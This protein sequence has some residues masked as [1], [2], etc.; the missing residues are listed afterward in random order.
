MFKKSSR[1]S[2]IMNKIKIAFL[3]LLLTSC[4]IGEHYLIDGQKVYWVDHIKDGM[5]SW[6]TEKELIE[7]ADAESFIIL[8]YSKY[9]KDKNFVYYCGHLVVGA[10]SET[11]V[12]ISN[13]SG[14]DKNNVY[15]NAQIFDKVSNADSFKRI[16]GSY[17]E[18]DKHIF[19]NEEILDCDYSSFKALDNEFAIDNNYMYFR[20]HRKEKIEDAK[21]LKYI[22]DF[23]CIDKYNYYRFGET[24]GKIC[25]YNT[26]ERICFD[27]SKDSCFVY[28]DGKKINGIN[29]KNFRRI[30][31][32]QIYFVNDLFVYTEIAGDDTIVIVPNANPK[33]FKEILNSNYCK[34]NDQVFYQGIEISRDVQ[35]FKII[36]EIT[37]PPFYDAYDKTYKYING[38][39]Y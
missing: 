30:P 33:Y 25:N 24:K 12:A 13:E 2:L 31:G 36:D 5:W 1:Y 6:H 37:D 15:F 34:D 10:N 3:L 7:D 32:N 28:L 8:N 26:F 35:N 19:Y 20:S 23:I 17:Y 22:G 4:D 29:P 9:A 21:S 27:V 14:K 18:D 16:L 11:F 38:K 39:R